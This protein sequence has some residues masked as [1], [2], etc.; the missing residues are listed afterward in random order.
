MN[1]LKIYCNLIRKAENRTLPE[2][3]VEKHH[4]F[5][6]SIF[7]KNNRIVALTAREHSIAHALLEKIYLKRCGIQ[8]WK[9]Q[10]MIFAYCN[11]NAS[12]KYH[13]NRYINSRLYESSRIR[14]SKI[15]S[16]E[17]NPFYGKSHSEKV[18]AKIKEA[19]IGK[20]VTITSDHAKKIS[21][22]K[23]GKPLSER[24][25]E[26]CK[27]VNTGNTYRLGTKHTDEAK[28]KMKKR[29]EGLKWWND[30]KSNVMKKECPGKEW[31]PGRLY[32]SR[33]K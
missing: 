16:G 14:K 29:R 25:R 24:C 32:F 8:N 18:I 5:P 31:N 2:G 23:K 20:S 9:T 12:N 22:S 3:Y 7:G 10:K 15:M 19:N 28:E 1:Y 27:E 11:M 26:R 17:N 6:K 33:N 13:K 30:G 21:E 4:T